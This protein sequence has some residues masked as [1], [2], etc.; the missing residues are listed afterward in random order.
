[1]VQPWCPSPSGATRGP[2]T[3]SCDAGL[4]ACASTLQDL[5][6]FSHSVLALC[7][8]TGAARAHA[9]G[10]ERFDRLAPVL[11]RPALATRAFHRYVA[12]RGP[13]DLIHLWGASL[14]CLEPSRTSTQGVAWSDLNRGEVRVLRGFEAGGAESAW[15]MPL[16]S[17]M[18]RERRNLLASREAT[19]TRLGLA[20][21][22]I[23]LALLA[24]PPDSAQVTRFSFLATLLRV[25]GLRVV[26]VVNS[27]GLEARRGLISRRTDLL[28]RAPIIIDGPI[29]GVLGACDVAICAPGTRFCTA[30]EPA[31]WRQASLVRVALD[32]GVP[33]VTP[34]RELLPEHLTATLLARSPHPAALA[35]VLARLS[36]DRASLTTLR[37]ALIE[38]ADAST[39]PS[40]ALRQAWTS[41][42][43]VHA[44]R[45]PGPANPTTG[46]VPIIQHAQGSSP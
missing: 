30:P 14:T 1:M 42:M 39:M 13:F 21:D 26:A 3:D 24:D 5:T 17:V 6:D 7:G 34:T 11:G 8:A 31:T 32:L 46:D 44:R 41:A 18:E 4:R 23:A 10:L 22:D 38:S 29:Q 43:G 25:S 19:R 15:E 37:R 45:R 12:E 36:E 27:H 16:A 9:L 20:P 2:A 28:E 35:R 33:V 40:I